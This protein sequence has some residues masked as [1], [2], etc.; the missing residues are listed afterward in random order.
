MEYTEDTEY[1]PE[2]ID[3]CSQLQRDECDVVQS[4]YP[5][6]ISINSKHTIKL[7][8]PIE[9]SDTRTVQVIDDGTLSSSSPSQVN[10]QSLPPLLLTLILP[11]SYPLLS[12]PTIVSL[13]ITHSWLPRSSITNLKTNLVGIWEQNGEPGEREAVL[14][15]WIDHLASGT[16]LESLHLLN[17]NNTIQ[18]PH[19]SP[20]HLTALLLSS[21]TS[22]SQ[23]IFKSTSHPCPICLSSL[24]GSKCI[25]LPG[26]EHTFCKP[27][28]EEYW[29]MCIAEGSVEGVGCPGETC[30][31]ARAQGS[32]GEG[33]K[34]RQV[35]VGEVVKRVCGEDGW[36]RWSWLLEKRDLERDPTII[37][38]PLEFCQ[39]PVPAPKPIASNSTSSW[40]RLRTCHECGYSFCAMCKRTWHG[41]HIPCPIPTT[42]TSTST[43]VLAQF[44]EEKANREWMEKCTTRCPN[45]EV[46]VEKSAGCNHMTC[47]RCKTHFC[48]R[49]A[50]KLN[51]SNP[52]E[53]FSTPGLGCYSKLFG[54]RS[55]EEEE[56]E[57]GGGLGDEEWW[58]VLVEDL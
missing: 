15:S 48:Y 18:I 1:T 42:S 58:P 43:F 41:P 7:E 20:T 11:Q 44:D 40:D 53:H 10:I 39:T 35:E 55:R 51:P 9:F 28:L 17:S 14:Y 8:I 6:Y 54:F 19:P 4:I 46:G 34:A 25:L 2:I 22:H 27:C 23:S 47:A 56:G 5:D 24:P 16:F 33:E 45:C 57:E 3:Q 31:K 21:S 49:C 50:Q 26:C 36:V 32:E 52:Y 38:C 30:V 13:S 12:P 29:G 37:H